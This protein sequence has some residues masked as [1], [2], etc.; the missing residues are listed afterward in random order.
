MNK[1]FHNVFKNIIGKPCWAVKPGHGT[2]L[3]L[4]FGEPYLEVREPQAA[5]TP[6]SK[7]LRANLARRR[8]RVVGEWHVWICFSDWALY[9][10]GKPVGDSSTKRSMQRA[11]DFLDGQKL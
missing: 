7:K 3:T 4:E 5:R 1:D 6:V 2:S 10:K 8:V 9:R 11:V